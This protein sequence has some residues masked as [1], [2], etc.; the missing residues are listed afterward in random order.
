[1]KEIIEAIVAAHHVG[2]GYKD[3]SKQFGVQLFC[4]SNKQL[5]EGNIQRANNLCREVQVT[6]GSVQGQTV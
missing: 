6:A 3:I 1:M 4:S 5:Q 2:K